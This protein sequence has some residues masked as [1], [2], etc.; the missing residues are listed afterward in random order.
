M[1]IPY[2]FSFNFFLLYFYFVQSIFATPNPPHILFILADDFGHY[3]ISTSGNPEAPTPKLYQIAQ[4]GIILNRHYTYKFCSP[5]RSSLMSG[6]LPIHV[7]VDNR[8]SKEAG[9]VDLRMEIMSSALKRLANYTT[10]VAG[11]WHAGAYFF[12]QLPSQRGFDRSLVYL[13][14]NEDHYSQYFGILKAY[15]LWEDDKPA[16]GKNGTYGTFMYVQH[17]LDTINN[18]D[19]SKASG[20]LFLYMPFQN[21]HTPLQVP[22]QYL[23]KSIPNTKGKQTFFGMIA[24]LDESVGNITNALKTKGLWENTLVI[25]SA[26]NGG[27]I[28][29]AGNNWPYRGGK[30]T[31]FEGGVR[32]AAFVGGGY[33]PK[34]QRG[35][36]TNISIHI[37][38]WWKTLTNLAHPSSSNE[39]KDGKENDDVPQLDSIDVWPA[40]STGASVSP[41]TEIPLSLQALIMGEMK[42]VTGEKAG[43]KNKWQNPEYPMGNSTPGPACQPCL[44]NL[45]ADPYEH[46]DLSNTSMGQQWITKLSSRLAEIATTKFQTGDD[47]YTGGY[48]NCTNI[49]SYKEQHQDFC[50][51]LCTF[52]SVSNTFRIE[53]SGMCL[54]T[55]SIAEKQIVSMASCDHPLANQWSL[56]RINDTE[57]VFFRIPGV[58]VLEKEW[59]LRPH[60]NVP[61]SCK[62]GTPI[63]TGHCPDGVGIIFKNN[64]LTSTA[65]H[66]QNLCISVNNMTASLNLCSAES[67]QDW[68]IVNSTIKEQ[69]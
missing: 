28:T 12:G 61:A 18:Y 51:P 60:P 42:Y 30:Y 20:P 64:Q 35:T 65:C 21:T 57:Y 4:E 7:N 43:G 52:G 6:R 63:I 31:D 3:D 49:E 44:F 46:I 11:K 14:G 40:L 29:S 48:D 59:C 8:P 37:C 24:C 23:N 68:K 17:T 53:K 9:G 27:E 15:D 67:T 69:L 26:D 34:S 41:R 47:G 16:I 39:Q 25:F 62:E 50:G 19:P 2:F 55:A 32:T 33:V 58:G 13:N 5:T 56:T 45:T 10:S 1:A 54:L 38:D 66:E 22:S 36:S